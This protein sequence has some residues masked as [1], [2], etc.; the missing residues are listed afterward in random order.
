MS[1][2]VLQV[3]RASSSR[4]GEGLVAR[5]SINN[6]G[7]NKNVL[8]PQRNG[9][10]RMHSKCETRGASTRARLSVLSSEAGRHVFRARKPVAPTSRRD[11]NL[12]VSD[13]TDVYRRDMDVRKLKTRRFERAR[14]RSRT[15]PR[16]KSKFFPSRPRISVSVRCRSIRWILPINFDHSPYGFP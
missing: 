2:S 10:R 9:R 16:R 1:I 14:A 3:T 7:S 4:R 6:P 12:V 8:R 11:R 13:V 15:R 5:G